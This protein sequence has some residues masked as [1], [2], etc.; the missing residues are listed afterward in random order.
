MTEFNH[1]N[2]RLVV[3]EVK[4]LTRSLVV[5]EV[6]QLTSRGAGGVVVTRTLWWGRGVHLNV[7]GEDKLCVVLSL[8]PPGVTS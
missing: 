7:V 5:T 8:C 6:N 1:L 3:T 4:Q 2:S